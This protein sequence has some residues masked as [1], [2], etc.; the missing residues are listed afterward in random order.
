MRLNSC[1]F[2]FPLKSGCITIGIFV[3]LNSIFKLSRTLHPILHDEV[4][5]FTECKFNFELFVCFLTNWYWN[6]SDTCLI[7][8]SIRLVA[9]LISS[10]L[11]IM[12][13]VNHMDKLEKRRKI[14]QFLII[15]A[16]AI[17]ATF[18]NGFVFSLYA[19]NL[20]MRIIISVM[21]AMIE[22]YLWFVV[23]SYYDQFKTE[24]LILQINIWIWTQLNQ[25]YDLFR[26]ND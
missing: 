17:V 13:I 21:V 1:C 22:S 12:G 26:F 16:L 8:E 25:I 4:R 9:G 5:S 18:I 19:T 11:L 3:F 14:E 2:C 15:Y 23:L 7:F 10:I 20:V 6:I 24:E